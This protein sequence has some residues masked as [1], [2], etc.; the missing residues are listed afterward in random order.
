M[1][2]NPSPKRWLPGIVALTLSQFVYAVPAPTGASGTIAAG[3]TLTIS[4]ANFGTTGP[5][6]VLMED[7][8]R[9]T[10]GQKVKLSG[11]PVGAWTGYNSSNN[12]LAS[13]NAHTG[14]VG[15]HA[16]DYA[17]QGANIL[18]LALGGQYSEAFISFWVSI[19]SGKS[20]P[21]MWGPG[22]SAPPPVAGQFSADS[23]WKYA[24]LLQTS[25]SASISS[26]FDLRVLDYSG[27]N[28]FMPAESNVGYDMVI[29]GV[30]S[31]DVGTSW[32]TWNGWN[33]ISEWVRGNSTVPAGAISGFFQVVN[34]ANSMKTWTMG[35]PVTYPTSAMFQMGVPNYFTQ[36]NVP[37]WIRE[38]SGP[39][40]DPTYD[41]IYIAVG[42]GSVA[43]A[44]LTDAPTYA[45]SK[46]ATILRSISWS[47]T[48]LTA[49]VPAAG[50]DFTGAAY[51]YVTDMTGA[52]NA[53]GISIGNVGST[54]GGSS[55]PPVPNP[56][57]NISVQ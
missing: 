1:S 52:T 34:A 22:G 40:A 19:P 8:E 6:V 9:D 42:P 18:N 15:F 30:D 41:D 51:L 17:G 29:Q 16:Y 33:R 2:H 54:S 35:N 37:G 4:G 46:H 23:S 47:A 26:Q 13:P 53:V 44:E 49:A 32:W 45:A 27:S 20:F 21:G 24:W 3:Q 56:P 7:F 28:Q 39:N 55:P 12:F 43:R 48:K 14:S 5:T 38:N 11:A 57:T 50:L 31:N 25:G 10:A 36:I